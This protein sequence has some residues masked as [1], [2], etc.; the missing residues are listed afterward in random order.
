M[1]TFMPLLLGCLVLL[2][3][4]GVAA[5]REWQKGVW[6]DAMVE[7]PRVTV[8]IV[9][10]DPNHRTPQPASA[11]E[12]R[13]YVIETATHRFELQQDATADTAR[14]DAELGEPVTFAIEKKNVY[15]KDTDGRE[16]R[17]T[18]TKQTPLSK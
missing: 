16:H 7:R 15:V 2:M 8:G 12:R 3:T 1:R 4:A 6:R 17:L 10:G 5:E 9:T 14:V 13:K 18:L 11:R